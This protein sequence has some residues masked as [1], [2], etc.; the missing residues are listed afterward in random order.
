MRKPWHPTVK[1][2]VAKVLCAHGDK[3]AQRSN[4]GVLQYVDLH[5]PQE[6]ETV[7]L[8]LPRPQWPDPESIFD[9]DVTKHG[10]LFRTGVA[11]VGEDEVEE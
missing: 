7:R 5:E 6:M 9:F 11:S 3:G 8:I 1:A 4:D 10:M 2:V